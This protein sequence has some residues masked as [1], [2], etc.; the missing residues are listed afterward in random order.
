MS[1]SPHQSAITNYYNIEEKNVNVIEENKVEKNTMKLMSWNCNTLPSKLTELEIYLHERKIDVCAIQEVD[2]PKLAIRKVNSTFKLVVSE[3]RNVPRFAFVLRKEVLVRTVLQNASCFAIEFDWR[4]KSVVFMNYY[5]DH[6]MSVPEWTACLDEVGKVATDYH[7]KGSLV[8]IAGDVN[9]HSH[10]WCQNEDS[11]G[12]KFDEWA[13]D[14]QLVC[15]NSIFAPDQP[16]HHWTVNNVNHHST[17]DAAFMCNS[18]YCASMQID[19]SFSCSDHNPILIVIQSRSRAPNIDIVNHVSRSPWHKLKDNSTKWKDYR[20]KLS[21]NLH[22]WKVVR[23]RAAGRKNDQE[24]VECLWSFIKD[25]IHKAADSAIGRRDTKHK[26]KCWWNHKVK[27]AYKQ[28]QLARASHANA[29]GEAKVMA[30]KVLNDSYNVFRKTAMTAKEESWLKLCEKLGGKK[31]KSVQWKVFQRLSGRQSSTP[32]P[33]PNNPIYKPTAQDSAEFLKDEYI[34]MAQTPSNLKFSGEMQ[35]A[36]DREFTLH[37]DD[38]KPRQPSSPAMAEF[39]VEQV[40]AIIRNLPNNKAPGTDM[41][42]GSMLK[43]GPDELADALCALFNMSWER[44]TIPADFKE[45]RIFSLYKGEADQKD[46]SNYRPISLTSTVGKA[47]EKL[48]LTQL[49]EVVEPKLSVH[50]AGFRKRR[51]TMDHLIRVQH[52]IKFHCGKGSIYPVCF[53]DIRRA[54]DRVPINVLLSKLWRNYE[55]R[56]K[57]WRWVGSFLTNRTFRA[58]AGDALSSVGSMPNGV[59]QGSV[60]SPILFDC[61]IDDLLM[62]MGKA[63]GALFADDFAM[64]T[65][66]TG[67]NAARV[68]NTAL[69]NCFNWAKHNQVEFNAKKS[70]VVLFTRSHNI[71]IYTFK[72]GT[73]TIPIVD[74][75]KYLG[76]TF[77]NSMSWSEHCERVQLKLKRAQQLIFRV[78]HNWHPPTAFVLRHLIDKMMHP[79]LTYGFPIWFLTKAWHDRFNSIL[80]QTAVR[81]LGLPRGSS[82]AAALVEL[83]ILDVQHMLQKVTSQWIRRYIESDSN[84]SHEEAGELS[85]R[86]TKKYHKV[87]LMNLECVATVC[88]RHSVAPIW[89]LNTGNP[90][91]DSAS[92]TE[93]IS[94]SAWYFSSGSSCPIFWS[95]IIYQVRRQADCNDQS[96]ASFRSMFSQSITCKTPYHQHFSELRP[97]QFE[98]H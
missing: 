17:I 53:L 34:K 8:V 15:L 29:N 27:L 32:C 92:S 52:A 24:A 63:N 97:M 45:A 57:L 35:S 54:Y 44:G 33:V 93:R 89:V 47:L 31:G 79:I 98:Q 75:F 30:K 36:Y 60:L 6:C 20:E 71:P 7:Q 23:E 42:T 9:A 22:C 12:K 18:S 66:V 59:P 84:P 85:I 70:A 88:P 77:Q 72:I 5:R 56:G 86:T 83:G 80:G 58:I 16:T 25:A 26:S 50:Q 78:C 49:L 82:H 90:P 10:L 64:W 3:D 38:T 87:A 40:S 14:Y 81:I 37:L 39:C 73:E 76:V 19:S 41:I 51:A 74:S 43:R 69:Q 28:L 13:D 96:S 4:G 94:C 67:R 91:S 68:L 61:F 62:M 11:N 95:S 48:I 1:K 46:P 2:A 21:I 55:V 65:N